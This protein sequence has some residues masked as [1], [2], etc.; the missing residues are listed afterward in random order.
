VNDDRRRQAE[1]KAQADYLRHLGCVLLA[2][3]IDGYRNDDSF[4]AV[5]D[6]PAVVRVCKTDQQCILRW[7][8]YEWIDPVWDVELIVP[9]HQLRNAHGFW[10]YGTSYNANGS[11]EPAR[12]KIADRKQAARAILVGRA[13]QAYRSV[14]HL[15]SNAH[16]ALRHCRP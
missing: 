11:T 6:S 2:D 3:E 10:I 13:Y 9:H 5:L 4:T 1:V 16:K 15:A 7:M 14:C 12:W 8:D